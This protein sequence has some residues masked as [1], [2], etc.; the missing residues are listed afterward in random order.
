LF[1]G[2]RR[3]LDSHRGLDTGA[4]AIARSLA[5]DL[6]APLVYSDTSRLLVDLNRSPRHRGLF[7][8][9]TRPCG[10]ATRADILRRHYRPY[11]EKL[12]NLIAASLSDS[13]PVLHLSIHSFTSRL[14]GRERNAGIGLLYDPAR[15][16]ERDFCR[17]LQR[18]LK[19][20]RPDVNVR[21]NYPYRGNAD[22]LTTWF[23]KLYDDAEYL[24]IEIEINQKLAAGNGRDI[25]RL[26]STA[27]QP[28]M[29]GV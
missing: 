4:L 12:Q 21:L 22:G 7:S 3:I 15:K 11:R 5:C 6:D 8:E 14:G 28:A 24:G 10:E 9:F 23:R 17:S 18:E 2:G 25:G 16:A 13:R 19:D 20:R 29:A 26:L 1:K 27:V